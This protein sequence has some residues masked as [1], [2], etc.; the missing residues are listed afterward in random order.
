VCIDTCEH[1]HTHG[2]LIYT[3]KGMFKGMCLLWYLCVGQRTTLTSWFSPQNMSSWVISLVIRLCNK[4][5]ELTQ[6]LVS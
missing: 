6:P 4:L 2:Y 5:R 3:L 1:V